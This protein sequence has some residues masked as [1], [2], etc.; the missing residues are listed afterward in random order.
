MPI[1]EDAKGPTT[2][3]QWIASFD[4]GGRRPVARVKKRGEGQA[5]SEKAGKQKAPARKAKSA[6][7][8]AQGQQQ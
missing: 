1:P 2:M 3:R 8:A 7:K 5:V 4:C 6:Q